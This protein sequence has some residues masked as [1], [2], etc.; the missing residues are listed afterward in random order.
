MTF[1]CCIVKR[2]TQNR[3]TWNGSAEAYWVTEIPWSFVLP[4]LGCW[5]RAQWPISFFRELRSVV[6]GE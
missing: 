3:E 4:Q 6:S 1:A 2:I 5:A